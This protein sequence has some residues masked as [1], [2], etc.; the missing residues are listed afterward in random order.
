MGTIEKI[1]NIVSLAFFLK[2]VGV[3]VVFFVLVLARRTLK[4]CAS[5]PLFRIAAGVVFGVAAIVLL[6]CFLRG[7]GVL[8]VLGLGVVVWLLLSIKIV[9]PDEMAVLILFGEPIGFRD[10]GFCFVPFLP[11]L[12]C[13][14]KRYPKKMYNFA[15]EEHKVI[16]KAGEYGDPKVTYGSQVLRVDSVAYL[17]FPREFDPSI[18][19]D[20]ET[21]PLIKILRAG[22]PVDDTKLQDWTEEVVVGALRV[23]F[24]NITWKQAVEDLKIIN[25]KVE[26]IFKDL[27]GALLRAGFRPKGIKLIIEEIKLPPEL[28]DAL[29]EPDKARLRA[30]AAKN[31]AKARAI[32]I[33]GTLVEM[34][35]QMTGKTQQEISDDINKNP[36]SRKEFLEWAEGKIAQIISIDGNKDFVHIKVDGL[37][38]AGDLIGAI[39]ALIRTQRGGTGSKPGGTEPRVKQND[40]GQMNFEEA[41]EYFE[42]EYAD[43]LDDEEDEKEEVEKGKKEEK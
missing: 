27:D 32:E 18:D 7:W 14:L 25:E 1:L 16:T 3:V 38:N 43:E 24:G 4:K 22:I 8:L 31:K 2:L 6:V 21:H 17:N 5:N 34:R 23:A 15:Y 37:N 40:G 28:E 35:A 12:K 19:A 13:Y 30:D 11:K 9:G 39:A 29:V 26:V 36:E 41:D 42:R 20:T 10:N 33:M